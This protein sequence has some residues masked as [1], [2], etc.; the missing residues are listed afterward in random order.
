MSFF[1]TDDINSLISLD[2]ATLGPKL[3]LP[4]LTLLGAWGGFPDAPESFKFLTEISIFK[5]VFLWVLVMQG[6]AG[7]D[8]DLSLVAVIL[9]YIL[10]EGIKYLER[11]SGRFNKKNVI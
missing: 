2:Y 3:F 5:Y 7:S 6:G 10:T 9:F 11:R 4:L 8:F 1:Q